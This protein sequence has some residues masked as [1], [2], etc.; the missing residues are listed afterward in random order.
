M[1]NHRIIAD[2]FFFFW[3]KSGHVYQSRNRGR[4]RT[5]LTSFFF[6]PYIYFVLPI[7]DPTTF[8][9]F[10]SINFLTLWLAHK[11]KPIIDHFFLI[12]T[13]SIEQNQ[14][15]DHLVARRTASRKGHG[16]LKKTRS[17]LTISR[18]MVMVTGEPS[19]KMP[20]RVLIFAFYNHVFLII[21]G[22]W[23]VFNFWNI[24]FLSL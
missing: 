11:L 12:L 5:Y 24:F 9:S 4:H 22:F 3:D 15:E 21:M 14:W 18:N 7:T 8:I 19:P 20:V 1:I 16:H 2:F 13:P 6:Y 23:K 10:F 17:S